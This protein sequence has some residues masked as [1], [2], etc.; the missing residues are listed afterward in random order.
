MSL[1]RF[2]AASLIAMWLLTPD[3]LC[4]LPGVTLTMDEHECCRQMG[5][6]CGMVPMPETHKC[7]QAVK[8]SSAVIAS[9]ITGYPEPQTGTVAFVIPEFSLYDQVVHV[10]QWLRF[11]SPSPPRLL[12]PESFAIL[13][14]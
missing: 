11:E 14:I 5:E 1:S 2:I 4:L 12:S 3:V 10:R 7:C 6:Q 13:R 9:K 8:R